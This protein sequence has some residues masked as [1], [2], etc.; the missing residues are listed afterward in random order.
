MAMAQI[1]RATRPITV[2]SGSMPLEKKKD[3]LG[4]KLSERHAAGEVVLDIGKTVGK[5]Q[6]QLGDGIGAGFGNMIS[7]D[8][9]RIKIPHIVLSEILLDVPHHAQC[10]IGGEDTGVLSLILLENISLHRASDL[11]QNIGP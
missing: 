10:E 8:G 9:D 4:P 6:G 11:G 1:R 5:S 2:Y 3:R 7:G